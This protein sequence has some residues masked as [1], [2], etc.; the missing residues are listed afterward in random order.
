M[1]NS[2]SFPYRLV[3]CARLPGGRGW[4]IARAR[5][6]F[7]SSRCKAL[8]CG[9]R[10]HR[11]LACSLFTQMT[12]RMG[13]IIRRIAGKL[14]GRPRRFSKRIS[15][16]PARTFR[17]SWLLGAQLCGVFHPTV[18]FPIPLWRF[19][20]FTHDLR[21]DWRTR[22]NPFVCACQPIWRVILWR[23]GYLRPF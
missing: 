7:M 9:V 15:P 4:W 10:L 20:L 19:S 13:G 22:P 14:G 23:I 8:S 17:R 3:V 5:L 12:R 21:S 11:L 16:P 1:Q 18:S 6:P 2:S